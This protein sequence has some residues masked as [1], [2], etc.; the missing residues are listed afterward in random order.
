MEIEEGMMKSG[1]QRAE[2]KVGGIILNFT[3]R[4]GR[5]LRFARNDKYFNNELRKANGRREKDKTTE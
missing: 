1:G 2:S 3:K 4:P 5:L